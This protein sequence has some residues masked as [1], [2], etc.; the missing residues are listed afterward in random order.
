MRE[1]SF[2]KE[3]FGAKMQSS[4]GVEHRGRGRK[5]LKVEGGRA[6]QVNPSFVI[7]L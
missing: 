7:R 6:T 1:S 4:G 5:V 2:T 3:S